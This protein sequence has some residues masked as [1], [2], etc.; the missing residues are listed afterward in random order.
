MAD[1]KLEK[2]NKMFREGERADKK[3]FSEQRT[4]VLLRSGE[5]YNKKNSDQ[6]I[7][8]LRSRGVINR[9]QK[10]RLTKNH[11]HRVCNIYQNSIL[12][13]N[14]STVAEPYN[15][16]ELQDVKEAQMANGVIDWVK[17]TTS[18]D[19]KQEKFAHDFVTIGECVA[20][21]RFDYSKGP[22]SNTVDEESGEPMPMGE[23]AIDRV[24]GFDMKRDPNARDNE[25]TRWWIKE[26]MVDLEDFKLMA[27]DLSNTD[28]DVDKITSSSKGTYKIFDANNG[29]YR[30]TKD[31]IN[32]RELFHKPSIKYPNGWYAMFTDEHL[33]Y[34]DELPFGIY[35]VI[36][37][38]FDELTTSPRSSSIVRV[39]RPYQIEINRASSKMAE[40][41]IT[42]GDDKVFIQKGTKISAGGYMHGVRAFQVSGQQPLIQAGRNG[43]QYLEYQ[44]SQISEMYEAANLEF[45]SQ[46]KEAVGDP[47]Q[48]LF[49][50]MKEKKRFVK[51]VEK[52]GR[53]ER[54]IFQ[55]A[56]S[57]AKKYLTPEHVIKINGRSEIVNIP[58]FIEATDDGFEIKVKAQ[59]GDVETKFGKILGI[60]QTLQYT[61]SQLEPD[62]IG[63][64]I[65]QLPYGNDE[66]IFSTLTIDTD[67]AMND[68]LALDRGQQVGVN[69]NDNHKF[70]IK[71]LQH[72]MKKSD[73]RF[74]DPAIQQQYQMKLAQ[75]ELFFRQQNIEASAAQQG[76]IPTGGFLTTVNAS[77][78]NP[79]TNRVE[80][81]K[82]PSNA[83]QWL[84]ERITLQGN[85][86]EE[87][88]DLPPD[89]QGRVLQTPNLNVPQAPN[90]T[91]GPQAQG[92]FDGIGE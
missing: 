42:L 88:S 82:L 8:D 5:H 54:K 83:L 48:L 79:N 75:H 32:V 14:P 26:T 29:E 1:F 91:S 11:I 52:F 70:M 51:Y 23:I 60:T 6:M 71:S 12:E 63:T 53:F 77:A 69:A 72:R 89:S 20:V 44:L 38:G 74:L 65:R 73:F 25:E 18:Y 33:V 28:L 50:S 66:Q 67:N 10:I 64:L 55:T 37:E 16:D 30:E 90:V 56:I 13:T 80:R 21:V 84:V 68:I 24:F 36:I 45:V 43:A 19:E 76:M 41:Q 17:K 87:A 62:Q 34:Q 27:K 61:G 31:Q 85:M 49:R 86:L 81:I 35:P 4:N 3:L 15:K 92:V 2:L 22:K 58:E 78:F 47:Y 39:C 7:E 40:H 59:S 57:M 9:K 46:N